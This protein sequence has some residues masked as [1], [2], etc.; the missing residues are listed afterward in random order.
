MTG[1]IRPSV[2]LELLGEERLGEYMQIFKDVIRTGKLGHVT[3]PKSVEQLKSWF[4][5]GTMLF[6]IRNKTDYNG[7]KAG[8]VVGACGLEF[9]TNKKGGK[10]GVLVNSII[11]P[12]YRRLGFYSGALATREKMA[13]W[14]GAH[15]AVAYLK[16]RDKKQLSRFKAAGYSAGRVPILKELLRGRV[17]RKVRKPL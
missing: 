7:V 12:R 10:S 4:K 14:L 1:K 17:L 3:P 16:F 6:L 15:E 5:E 8:E 11:K 13:K 9:N 2:E